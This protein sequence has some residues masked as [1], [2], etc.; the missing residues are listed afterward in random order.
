MLVGMIIE[1]GWYQP[2]AKVTIG[3]RKNTRSYRITKL[4]GKNKLAF[5]FFICHISI[6]IFHLSLPECRFKPSF[7]RN[8]K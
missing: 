5:P 7:G 4:V 8:E 6:V 3:A 1:A 2:P